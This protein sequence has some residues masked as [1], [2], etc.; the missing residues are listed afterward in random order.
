M[1]HHIKYLSFY[2]NINLFYLI[3]FMSQSPI[4]IYLFGGFEKISPFYHFKILLQI[5]INI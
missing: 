5:K 1:F 2:S 4:F 3:E